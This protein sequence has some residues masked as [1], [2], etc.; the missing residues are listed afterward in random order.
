MK[1]SQNFEQAITEL[2]HIV[3]TLEK[4]DLALEDTLKK[5]EQGM[6][7][8]QFCQQALTQAQDRMTQLMND[9]KDDDKHTHD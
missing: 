1:P 2:E 9:G 5:F 3:N 8:S 7:L 4:G 6:K